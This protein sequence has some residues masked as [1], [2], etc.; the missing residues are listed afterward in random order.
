MVLNPSAMIKTIIL[1]L[2]NVIV[3]FDFARAYAAM[4]LECPYSVSEIRRRIGSTDLVLRFESGQIETMDFVRELSEMLE[5][6]AGFERFREIWICIFHKEALIP[7]S[8]LMALKKEYRLVLLSN[9]NA[10]HFE[11]LRETYSHFQHFDAYV[12]SH[13]VQSM[14]PSPKIYKEAIFKAECAAGE[15]F[16]TDDIAAYVEAAKAEGIDAVQFLSFEQLK[17]ELQTRGVRWYE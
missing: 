13:E 2:G 15:C 16:F 14:K 11:M 10:L 4:A 17:R 7:E 1:D 5:F 3:P 12:L 9:T 6:Q 8:F